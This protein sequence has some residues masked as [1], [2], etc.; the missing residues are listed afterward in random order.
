MQEW[1]LGPYYLS[2]AATRP[3]MKHPPPWSHF[4]TRGVS[5]CEACLKMIQRV[6]FWY[7]VYQTENLG[8]IYLN[9][10]TLDFRLHSPHLVVIYSV[11]RTSRPLTGAT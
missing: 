10:R 11:G 2:S 8:F 5:Q 6:S 9:L 4:E 1:G 7:N 3:Y